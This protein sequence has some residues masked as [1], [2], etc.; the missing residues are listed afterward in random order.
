MPLG[1][2]ATGVL[3]RLDSSPVL[4]RKLP[5]Q[6]P[7]RI[8]CQQVCH[9]IRVLQFYINNLHTLSNLHSCTDY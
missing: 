4:G 1:G 8:K 3:T 9:L 6:L 2:S 7:S 5:P